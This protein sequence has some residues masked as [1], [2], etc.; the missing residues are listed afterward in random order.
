M[1]HRVEEKLLGVL[2][3]CLS[4]RRSREA[5]QMNLYQIRQNLHALYVPIV[6]RI[7]Q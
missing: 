1:N 3:V 4:Q 7:L 6:Y 2:S 5:S